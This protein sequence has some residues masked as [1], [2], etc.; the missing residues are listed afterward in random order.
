MKLLIC[1]YHY[2]TGFI[3]WIAPTAYIQHNW[4]RFTIHWIIITAVSCVHNNKSVHVNNTKNMLYTPIVGGFTT[5][6][7]H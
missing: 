7:N 6:N 1:T 5:L 2:I 3:K 4:G